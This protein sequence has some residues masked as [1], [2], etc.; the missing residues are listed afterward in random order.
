MVGEVTHVFLKPDHGDP[1]LSVPEVT[2]VDGM[3]L[4]EDASFG[5]SKRQVLV[6]EAEILERYECKP[7]DFRE[8]LTLQGI[9]LTELQAGDRLEIGEAILEFQG[10]CHPCG[11]M[12]KL[13]PGL[14]AEIEGNRGILAAV[15]RGGAIRPG[16]KVIIRAS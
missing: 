16:D 12:D 13:K 3:G 9:R 5:R 10:A 6:V 2:A 14:Q 11:Q 7:G 15:V 1:M 4:R 8:N